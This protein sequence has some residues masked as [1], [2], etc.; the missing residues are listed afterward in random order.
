MEVKGSLGGLGA[1]GFIGNA[2]GISIAHLDSLSYANR[3]C[4]KTI[5]LGTGCAACT[6]CLRT[7]SAAV[8]STD[9]K[10]GRQC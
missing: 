8:K 7:R 10:T 3:W 9:P 1:G 5:Q 2:D 6:F 4:H